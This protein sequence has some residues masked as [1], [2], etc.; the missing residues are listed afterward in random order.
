MKEKGKR[1]KLGV[2]SKQVFIFFVP[3]NRAYETDDAKRKKSE[4]SFQHRGT[5][6]VNAPT[7]PGMFG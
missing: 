2:A 4:K 3:Q 5:D 1:K 6:T 7:L